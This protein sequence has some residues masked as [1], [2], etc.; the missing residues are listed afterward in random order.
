MVLPDATF[1]VDDWL[2]G[3]K[4]RLDGSNFSMWVA[5]LHVLLSDNDVVD[6]DCTCTDHL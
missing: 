2:D 1:P 3:E 4:P 6:D 5:R